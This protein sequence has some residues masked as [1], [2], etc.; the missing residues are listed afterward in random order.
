MEAQHIRDFT[1]L[2]GMLDEDWT[3]FYAG[4]EAEVFLR[5][6]VDSRVFTEV[7]GWAKRALDSGDPKEVIKAAVI[8]EKRSILLYY[9]MLE[10]TKG[11]SKEIGREILRQEKAHLAALSEAYRRLEEGHDL[12]P[13]L[14]VLR[15][16]V[17][18]PPPK[19][20]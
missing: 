15:R 8:A 4:T 17:G 18:Q 19:G 6:L 2:K 20:G 12:S 1:A 10:A 3:R 13:V 5:A 7:E 11:R 14:N 16:A 9:A